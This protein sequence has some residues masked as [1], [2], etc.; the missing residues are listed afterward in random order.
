MRLL[1]GEYVG[2]LPPNLVDLVPLLILA[3][4]PQRPGVLAVGMRIVPGRL[5]SPHRSHDSDAITL[6]M[7]PPRSGC[8]WIL[9][10]AKNS[11]STGA[12][13]SGATSWV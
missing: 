7:E 5:A 3:G 13:T 6:R 9:H 4:V 11:A 1:A 12:I 2:L 8:S 10:A